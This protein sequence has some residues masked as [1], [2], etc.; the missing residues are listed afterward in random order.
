MTG[1]A[2]AEVTTVHKLRAYVLDKVIVMDRMKLFNINKT[3][4]DGRSSRTGDS[5]SATSGVQFL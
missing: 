2:F 4:I 1:L 3:T 5:F